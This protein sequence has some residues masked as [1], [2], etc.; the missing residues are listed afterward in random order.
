MHGAPKHISVPVLDPAA[1]PKMGMYRHIRNSHF[2]PPLFIFSLPPQTF[3][4]IFLG[5]K[6]CSFWT[7]AKLLPV[8][9]SFNST[10]FFS[11]TTAGTFFFFPTPFCFLSGKYFWA[12]LISQSPSTCLS[13]ASKCSVTGAFKAGEGSAT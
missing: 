4:R 10:F 1:V 9:H 7:R 12:Y 6:K 8:S 5:P 2:S 13:L 3:H 11:V